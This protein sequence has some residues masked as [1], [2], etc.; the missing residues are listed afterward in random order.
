MI[1]CI[2]N[3][4][5]Y[6]SLNLFK[7]L[8]HAY[9]FYSTDQ[10]L[11]NNIALCFAKSL[12][13]KTH[14]ACEECN[15]CKQFD[16]SSHPD[17]TIINQDSIKVDDVNNIISKL[18]TLPI[19]SERKVFVILN[20]EKMNETAQNKLLKSLEEP[21]SS[22]LFILTCTKTDKLLPTVLSRLSKHYIQKLDNQDKLMVSKE[23]KTQNVDISKFL[24]TDFSL[25]E[26]I[27][28]ETND[29]H[30]KTLEAIKNIFTSLK[31][32]ADIPIVVSKVGNVDKSLF[33]PL[34]QDILL[35]CINAGG[36]FDY[37]TTQIFNTT[38]SKKAM[39]KCLPLIETA[40]KKQMSNVNFSYILDT[41]LFNILKEKFLCK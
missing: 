38:F 37:N 20:A 12:Q 29:S 6:K 9:L 24:T 35:D 1:K 27:N 33:L 26:M 7:T 36:K 18:N 23:L 19:S 4:S 30:K 17:V 28:F 16:S 2:K 8:S 34:L 11:N 31:T 14:S 21:N 3:T 10:E 32:T 22:N 39:V 40:Y 15:S 5:V 25:T 13:C 41:L